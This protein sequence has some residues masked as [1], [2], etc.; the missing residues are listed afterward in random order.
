M[1]MRE[2]LSLDDR[3]RQFGMEPDAKRNMLLPLPTDM[4]T[5]AD[6]RKWDMSDWTAPEWLY[7]GARA[8]NL[9]G[10]VARGGEYE[11][12]D[13]TDMGLAL[14]G[15]GTTGAAMGMSPRGSLGMFAGRGA[16]TA[17]LDQMKQAES[18]LD[19]GADRADVWQQ[20]GWMRGPD[21]KMRFEIDDSAAVANSIGKKGRNRLPDALSHPDLYDAY[22]DL[23]GVGVQLRGKTGM[24]SVY[25]PSADSMKIGQYAGVG[26]LPPEVRRAQLQETLAGINLKLKNLSERVG[27]RI[28]PGSSEHEEYIALNALWQKTENSAGKTTGSSAVPSKSVVLHETQHGIQGRE[29]FAEGGSS[30]G[31]SVKA[32]DT[33]RRLAGEAEARNVQTRMDMT[34]EQRLA[35]PPWTTLDVPEADQI[36]RMGGGGAQMS[37]ALLPMDEASRMARADSGGFNVDA[38]HGTR[39]DI[40]AFESGDIGSHFG[41]TE[42]A[43]K[44]LKGTQRDRGMDGENVLPVKLKVENSL[45][46]PDLGEWDNPEVAVRGLLE[47]PWGKTHE[48][49]LS[50]ILSEASDIARQFEDVDA[51]KASSEAADYLY[52]V[53][54]MI[55]ADGYDSIKYKNLVENKYGDEA[56]LRPDAQAKYDLVNRQYHELRNKMGSKPDLPPNSNAAQIRAWLDSPRPQPS[57][58]DTRMLDALLAER[59]RI[60]DTGG[61]DPYSYVVLDPSNIRSRFA[62]FDPARADSADILAMG[63]SPIAAAPL[64]VE[65]KQKPT[66]TPEMMRALA[67]STGGA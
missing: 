60:M 21:G 22:P 53:R 29:G 28:T 64:A 59:N 25:Y 49:E 40:D 66:I 38:Y 17:D 42:Q 35:E 30:S 10:H 1:D 33:Y 19:S 58:E 6:P 12:K 23:S 24:D 4:R 65:Q 34:P 32:Y 7:E 47:T 52:E 39:S 37:Q 14:M 56:G 62:A 61:N 54:R 15:M 41:T 48:S 2:A 43:N 27:G 5:E 57:P 45:E 46:L 20:T 50:E 18:M 63:G 31:R 36:V 51:W 16:K 8:F 26:D 3:M 13:V 67:Y 55:E 9:P 44:R 11:A